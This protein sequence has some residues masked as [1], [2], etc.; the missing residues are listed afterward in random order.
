MSNQSERVV[1]P[2]KRCPHTPDE[3]RF[4][5]WRTEPGDGFRYT[6]WCNGDA[7]PNHVPQSRPLTKEERDHGIP[8]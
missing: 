6:Y 7:D 1:W 2:E 3:H 8:G 5:V 4:H